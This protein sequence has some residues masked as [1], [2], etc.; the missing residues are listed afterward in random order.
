MSYAKC[1]MAECPNPHDE[2]GWCAFHRQ[3]LV[4]EIRW[5]PWKRV[6]AI[7]DRGAHDICGVCGAEIMFLRRTDD[8]HQ[9]LWALEADAALDGRCALGLGGF[10]VLSIGLAVAATTDGTPLYRTHPP[11]CPKRPRELVS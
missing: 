2:D 10:R 4:I 8:E 9:E 1:R 3:R 7:E 11:A 6:E 5:C